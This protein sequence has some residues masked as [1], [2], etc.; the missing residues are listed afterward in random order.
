[1]SSSYFFSNK[2]GVIRIGTV[3]NVYIN[4]GTTN[5]INNL[6]FYLTFDTLLNSTG[7]TYSSGTIY[8]PNLVTG[9]NNTSDTTGSLFKALSAPPTVQLSNT[10]YKYGTNSLYSN[11]NSLR[12]SNIYVF[13]QNTGLTFTIWA[14][15]VSHQ[16]YSGSLFSFADTGNNT[17]SLKLNPSTTSNPPST[18]PWYL[19]YQVDDNYGA[20]NDTLGNNFVDPTNTNNPISPNQWNHYAWVISPA[21]YGVVTTYTFYINNVKVATL[22]N[23]STIYPQ[24]YQRAYIDIASQ[25]GYTGLNGY[26]DTF[27]YYERNLSSIDIN[28]IYTYSDPNNIM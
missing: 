18:G 21:A 5:T 25:A 20:R 23:S 15:I 9:S 12:N 17:V 7:G 27:R 14:N 28:T 13:P 26:F 3:A 24:N 10:T 6:K 1:M 8:V 11:F 22:N 4:D 19:T 16:G 2:N